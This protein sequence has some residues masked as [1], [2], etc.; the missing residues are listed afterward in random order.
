MGRNP[1]HV[2]DARPADSVALVGVWADFCTRAPDEPGVSPLA[3]TAAAVARIAAEPGE[4]LLLGIIENHIV[5]AV[6]LR[7]VHISPIQAATAIH[8]SHLHVLDGWR[9][10]GVGRALLEAAVT[11]AEEEETGHILAASE[12][13]SREANRF[14]ARLGLGQVAMVRGTTVPAL[15]AKLPGEAPV[16]VRLGTRQHH[17][18]SRVLA[19]R[20]SQRRVQAQAQTQTQAQT[21]ANDLGE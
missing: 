13:N 5:G 9:R 18:L 7:R 6:Y 19:H 16:G 8:T 12:T 15:R 1:V 11:W 4:R 2:R 20:R 17:H 3:E 14:M 21:S 10:R